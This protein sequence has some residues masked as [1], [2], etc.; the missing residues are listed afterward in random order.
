MTRTAQATFSFSRSRCWLAL[1]S[2]GLISAL[3]GVGL[4]PV[5]IAQAG[6]WAQATCSDGGESVPAEGWAHGSFGG[7]PSTFGALDTCQQAGGSLSLRDEGTVDQSP[8]QGPMW[9]YSAPTFSTIAGG[10]M[11]LSLAS[12]GGQAYLATPAN[13]TTAENL[14]LMCTELCA[15]VKETTVPIL[16]LGGSQLFAVTECI[17]PSGKA[18]CSSGLNAQMNITS[19]TILLKN[20]AKP[21]GTSFAGTL[22]SNPASGAASLTFTAHDEHGPGVYRATVQIDGHAM[23]SAT[24]NLNEGKCVAHGTYNGALKFRNLQPC[25]P[26]TDIHTEIQTSELAEGQ[27]T[28]KVEVEDAAGNKATVYTGTITIDNQPPAITPPVV[29]VTPPS[30][31]ALNGDPASEQALLTIA[32]RQPKAFTRAQARSTTTLTGRLT[33]P[34]GTPIKG[35]QVQ[36]LQQVTGSAALTPIGSATTRPDGTWTLKAPTGPSRL[37]RIAYYSHAL[38]STPAAMLDFHER[39]QGVVSMHAPHHAKLGHAVVFSGQLAGGYV[40]ASGESVQME[41]F[42]GGRWRTIEVLPTTSKG[43]W[44]YRYVFTL[45]AGTSYLFRATTVPN[46]GYPFLSAHSKPVRVTVRR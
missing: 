38:D 23:W 25:P 6:E 34:T 15:S 16:Q 33:T 20:E 13:E 35:A 46:G 17:A 32:P 7:Y 44:T 40:P 2:L 5:A 31:G 19:A 43:R 41:I 3:V 8:E 14:V 27:H 11:T 29:S 45:G 9:V 39:V 42:Y 36:L 22:L 4:G 18:M 21:T 24:P 1:A 30:R 26:E 10:T 37:L 12:P 28:L